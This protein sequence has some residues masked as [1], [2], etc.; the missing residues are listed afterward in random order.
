MQKT[1]QLPPSIDVWGL[2]KYSQLTIVKEKSLADTHPMF[3]KL[4]KLVRSTARFAALYVWLCESI[5]LSPQATIEV[6]AKI[7]HT[8]IML[9]H[10]DTMVYKALSRLVYYGLFERVSKDVWRAKYRNITN[11]TNTLLL[12]EAQ[13][14]LLS[15]KEKEIL[16]EPII[17]K[18]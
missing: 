10:N 4:R 1:I 8:A 6:D 9:G 3:K 16:E 2:M 5:R 13:K 7:A 18:K 15:Q 12:L 11:I 17:N 14:K